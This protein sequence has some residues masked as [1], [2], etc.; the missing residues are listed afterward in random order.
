MACMSEAPVPDQSL[1]LIEAAGGLLVADDWRALS[2]LAPQL[3]QTW[4]TAQ[5]FRTNT[6]MRLSVLNDLKRPTPDAKYWQ[7]T[8]EQDV[9]LNELVSLSYEYRKVLLQI[10]R[11]E[12]QLSGE[13]DEIEREA[14]ALEI[15]HQGWIAEQMSRTAHHR[16]REIR[17]WADIKQELEPLLEYGTEDVN[18][19]QLKAMR[20]RWAAESRLVNEHTP[21]A[22]AANILGLAQAAMRAG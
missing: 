6:E 14:L 3:R 18:A 15:E 20:L 10:R 17:A 19:H 22:D 11:L 7:A 13:T 2:T 9:F 8:R 12:R 4:E 16:V 5:V 1:A 21:P